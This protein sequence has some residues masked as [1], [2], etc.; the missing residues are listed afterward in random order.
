MK[1]KNVERQ[2]VSRKWEDSLVVWYEWKWEE[3][4]WKE[5]KLY[6]YEITWLPT[7]QQSHHQE[8]VPYTAYRW[9]QLRG[10]WYF[11]RLV[12]KSKKYE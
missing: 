2:K 9:D 4:K 8:Q 6:S 7:S 3:I 1:G 11:L 12:K 10:K 5:R